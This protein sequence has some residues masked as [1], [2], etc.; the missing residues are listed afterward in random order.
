MEGVGRGDERR[1]EGDERRFLEQ[2]TRLELLF[3]V[4]VESLDLCLD[5]L[6]DEISVS[7]GT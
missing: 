2:D 3:R 5:L 1:D 7:L 6:G 4:V